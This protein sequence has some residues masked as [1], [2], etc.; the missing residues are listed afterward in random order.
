MPLTA[1]IG[2]IMPAAFGFV[3]KGWAACDGSL[4]G[5]GQNQ[6]LFAILGT[7]FGGDGVRTFALPDLRGRAILGADQGQIPAGQVAGAETVMLTASQMP[8]HSHAFHAATTDGSGRG[9]APANN[10]FGTATG[11]PAPM[12]FAPPDTK[13]I[14]MSAGSN[15]Q[16]NGGGAAH[17]N[18]QPYLVVNYV[19]A[20]TGVFP[21][22][23]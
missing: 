19:I 8:S 7:T 17:N 16:N 1:Y 9:S 23:N 13:D 14:P 22:R 6:A 11:N 21:S 18:M 2:Q 5:I 4:L 15:V 20:T 12:I 10:V 3:P